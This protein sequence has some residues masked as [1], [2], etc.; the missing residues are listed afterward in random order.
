MKIKHILSLLALMAVVFVSCQKDPSTS[1]L[2]GEYLVYTNHDTEASFSTIDT[3]Y[4]PDSILL[5]GKEKVDQAGNKE[6]V[7]WKDG[8][9]QALINA[10]VVAM[11]QRGF[12]RITDP[13]Q[14][15]TADAGFQLSYVENTT[16][17]VGYDHPYWWSYYPYYW[18]PAYWGAWYGWYYPFVV[19]YYGYT[20]GSLLAEMVDLRSE[21]GQNR[22]LPVLW[23]CYISGLIGNDGKINIPRTIEAIDEAFAQS[24]YLRK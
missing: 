21:A 5:I 16:Y 13:E 10:F 8:D 20:T 17:F 22:S 3:Y 15:S 9:A 23:N 14:R 4:I 12:M 7:Y 18:E 24:P 6:A 1:G 19:T 2:R 11:N